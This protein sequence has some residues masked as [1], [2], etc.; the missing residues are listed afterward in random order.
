MTGY[1][2]L[3]WYLTLKSFHYSLYARC[4][5]S[6]GRALGPLGGLSTGQLNCCLPR[7][8]ER[9]EEKRRESD[10]QCLYISGVTY[11]RQPR[12]MPGGPRTPKDPNGPPR[13]CTKFASDLL[14]LSV[15]HLRVSSSLQ[16]FRP[17]LETS[18]KKLLQD[19]CVE[20]VP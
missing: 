17:G 2:F 11:Q 1:N 7:M 20:S 13:W 6:W 15:K 8:E 9:R 16:T 18:S 12:Q 19:I 14:T 10:P 5:L 4:I 3:N